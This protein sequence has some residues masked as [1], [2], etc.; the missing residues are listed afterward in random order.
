MLRFLLL[1]IL[2]GFSSA[3]FAQQPVSADITTI[4]EQQKKA[5][6]I[7]TEDISEY[8]ISSSYT[9]THLN[10]THVY[11]EQR[12]K[13][14]PLFNGILN[15]NLKGDELV[16]FGNRWVKDI[17]AAVPSNLPVITASDAVTRSAAHL[18][19][20]F[21][22]PELISK[23]QNK[24][25]Q[26]VKMIFAP[27]NLSR[28]EIK[29]SLVWLKDELKNVHLC[30]TVEIAEIDNEN[31]WLVFIDAHSG[32]YLR[33]DNLV[34]HCDFGTPSC[35]DHQNHKSIDG[36]KAVENFMP[37]IPDS[38]YNIFAM[39]VESPNHGTRTI[40]TRPW[41]MAG[42]G[43]PATTLRWHNNG[44]T[45]YTSTRGNNV[46]AYEDI[47][48]D[49]VPG[50]TPDTFNLRFD[51][52]YAPSTTPT[53]NLKSSI[54]NLFY[55]NNIIHDVMY[56]Y[57]FDEVSGNFQNNN[58]GRGGLASDYVLA[59]AQD[60]GGTNNANFLTPVDGVKPRMQ[61]YIWSPVPETSPLIIN[62]PESIEGPMAA[63][64]SNFSTNNK[65]VNVG[66]TTDDLVLVIDPAGTHEGCATISNGAALAGKIAVID[67]GNCDFVTKVK[68]VQNY[69][70]VAAIV[71]NNIAGAPI[72][73]GG[74][75]NTIVIPAVMISLN[76]GNQLKGVMATDVVNASLEAVPTITPDGDFDNG[77]ISHEYG[78]GI[79]TRLTGGP[80]NSN[81]LNN[82]EQMGEGWSDFFA[83]MLT[84]DWT[85]A[86][87]E[88]SRGIGTF[89]I[90]E[91][92]GGTGIRT[93]PYTTD[94]SVNP[95]TY[96]DVFTNPSV[97]FIG[98]VWA[99]MLWDMA[100]N[101]IEM[102]GVD[103][104]I[105]DGDGGNNIAL[106]L[107]IDGLKLQ[108]CSPGFVD[109]RDAILL[110]D[111]LNYGG[112]HR[113]AIWKAFAGRGLGL[114]A[115]QGSSNDY[116]DGTESFTLPDG[117]RIESTTEDP[118]FGEGQGVTFTVKATCECVGKSDIEIA[119]VLSDDL[120]Y[121]PG[122]GGTFSGDTVYFNADTLG[123]LDSVE[124]TYRA[125][126]R[127]CSAT[128]STTLSQDAAEG[129]DQ[130]I[131]IKLLGTGTRV[132]VKSTALAVSPTHSWYAQNYDKLASFALT[133]INPVTASPG[134]LRI[135]FDHRY[136]TEANYDGGVVEYSTNNG[137]TWLDAE[138]FFTQN[139]YPATINTTGTD[140]PI[141]GQN[142][143]TGNSNVQFNTNTFIHS[144]IVIPVFS[145][146]PLLVR[147]RFNCDGSVAGGG[148]NGWYI[149][150]IL[151]EHVSGI[152][153]QT[154]VSAEEEFLT[155]LNYSLQTS[156]FGGTKLFVFGD[157][158]GELSGLSWATAMNELR[159]AL[160]I[161]GCRSIDSLFI[162]EGTYL[163]NLLNGRQSSFV[164]PA[165][166]KV[167]GGFPEGGSPFS[168]RNPAT[169]VAEL[170]GDIGIE[171]NNA[172]NVYH[173]VRIDSAAQGAILDG[174]TIRHGNANGIG[175]N[176]Q[177]A[178]VFCLGGLTLQN[179]IMN[180]NVGLTNGQQIRVR[181]AAAHLKL[182]DCLIYSPQDAFTK[183]LSTNGSQ[184]TIQGTTQ[185]LKE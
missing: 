35:S 29:T 5:I 103:P 90:G 185:F 45:N 126:V 116:N 171:N 124:F 47:N 121:I 172:D 143:F 138:P 28:V 163:P 153:N 155:S 164:I 120:I 53:T 149:D 75:D 37:P 50:V 109:G 11:L 36:I 66:L 165:N 183:L 67:R 38:S 84:T 18:G 56:Q 88:D 41:L 117:I 130:Y 52:P 113:C 122:S 15:L 94:M 141:A 10:I 98:S 118:M 58:L 184:V 158:I 42:I 139:G 162:G 179:V 177:G 175:D 127:P 180:N 79:S 123:V 147:F 106:Q 97:H 64:E 142:A 62:S 160:A 19:H 168:L 63:I 152:V 60:G 105:Y 100:W 111:E 107:V 43:N 3:I 91:V 20:T 16:S 24:L 92:P 108:P 23:E 34:I 39:P 77:I 49:N 57:G 71:I 61:M 32:E 6:G 136:Q 137:A 176:S 69:G 59:E 33:K 110:A 159:L 146:T 68:N 99:T 96:A 8:V 167:F 89:V 46:H 65:L 178:A 129:P 26:D 55:W 148:I 133:L 27:G 9:T 17:H 131:S 151:I 22:N 85:N 40:S 112:I 86:A 169:F 44:T 181:N 170:S 72:A 125:F 144:T 1:F 48:H 21:S 174:V 14:I 13:D 81:C 2:G 95:F 150:N 156:I 70:A 173:V 154:R 140:S 54:T 102:E 7:S 78:H 132:W 115:D 101:I 145:E 76:D 114:D 128:A 4:L 87:A 31:I 161:A 73:M 80:A 134:P 93:Y 82:Q 51:Y 182:K 119:D 30:W 12:F 25:G 166:T 157:A 135:S 74:T 83:L 104:D